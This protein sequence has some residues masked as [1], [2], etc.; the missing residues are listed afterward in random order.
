M[1][2]LY[3]KRYINDI[4][5]LR[6]GNF[7]LTESYPFRLDS[8]VLKVN[9]NTFSLGFKDVLYLVYVITWDGMKPDTKKVH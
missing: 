2:S 9:A 6:N 7:R 5:V 3:L 4:L 1:I 8:Y